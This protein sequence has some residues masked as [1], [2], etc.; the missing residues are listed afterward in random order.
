M[1]PDEIDTRDKYAMNNT[2]DSDKNAVTV[3]DVRAIGLQ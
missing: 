3:D 1:T 2:A